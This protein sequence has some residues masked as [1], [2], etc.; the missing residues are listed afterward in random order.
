MEINY[1]NYNIIMN[2]EIEKTNEYIKSY[3]NNQMNYYNK[4]YLGYLDNLDRNL[5]TYYQFSATDC[6]IDNFELFCELFNIDIQD[7]MNQNLI[8]IAKIVFD[9]DRDY[10]ARSIVFH[11]YSR[12]KKILFTCSS[13][14]YLSGKLGKIVVTGDVELVVKMFEYFTANLKFKKIFFGH[15]EMQ[16]PGPAI[17]R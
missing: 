3:Y 8:R 10:I 12:D 1:D 4:K 9:N 11:F 5:S 13:P 17:L 2:N 14:E 16:I 7:S 6:S 15:V